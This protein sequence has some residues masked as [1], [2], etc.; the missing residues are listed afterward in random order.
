MSVLLWLVSVAGSATVA[1]YV[2]GMLDARQAGKAK[3]T[4][5]ARFQPVRVHDADS[6]RLFL[7]DGQG[8]GRGSV[9][10]LADKPDEQLYGLH[11]AVVAA[12]EAAIACDVEHWRVCFV[13]EPDVLPLVYET[14]ANFT[15]K[16]RLR[17]GQGD[18]AGRQFLV[19]KRIV[20]R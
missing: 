18:G 1:W 6:T 8:P 7:F 11:A 15:W 2:R 10:L 19:M 4:R 13:I 17:G 3:A 5:A 16:L 12:L 9:E 14:D 20:G